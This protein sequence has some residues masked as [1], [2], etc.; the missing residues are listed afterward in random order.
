MN[1]I[2]QVDGGLGKS[3]ASTAV[4]SAIKKK[5][6]KKS[7]II[8]VTSFPDVFLNN[9]N[10]YKTIPSNQLS[11][12]YEQYIKG[13]KSKIFAG[14]P[15]R[16]NGFLNNEEHLFETWCRLCGV[17]YNGETPEFYLT[18]AEKEYFVPVY[19]TE[20]PILVLHTNGGAEGQQYNYSWTRDIPTSTVNNVINHY[21]ESHTII[22]IRR[23]DQIQYPNT[24]SALDGYR[25]IAI[26]LL[27]SDKRLLIDSFSQHLAASLN[28]PS[29]VCWSTTSPKV[30]GYKMHKNIIATPFSKT[31]LYN[32]NNAYQAFSLYEDI[33]SLP[34]NSIDE[35]FNDDAIIKALDV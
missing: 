17:K 21:K 15:Y 25:S 20:K 18:E 28:L 1:I 33:H 5:Y 29:V 12:I 6:G 31:P 19:Q 16:Q 30:F 14:E 24:L 8:V 2:F 22:H 10:V 32:V 34:Y 27:L 35:I 11:G 26:M 23:S 9:P 13:K 7:N 4:I 3:I